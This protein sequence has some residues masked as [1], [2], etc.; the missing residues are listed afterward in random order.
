MKFKLNQEFSILDVESFPFRINPRYGATYIHRMRI[1]EMTNIGV[2]D[3]Q[4]QDLSLSHPEESESLTGFAYD[5]ADESFIV[6][7]EYG[8]DPAELRV[9]YSL[10]GLV[11]GV[12]YRYWSYQDQIPEVIFN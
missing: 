2:S 10:Y 12:G 9:S 7:Q 1:K 3:L 4:I 6:E 5:A 11:E 8:F